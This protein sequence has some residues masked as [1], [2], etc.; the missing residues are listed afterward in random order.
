[1]WL[2]RRSEVRLDV[3][4][5][6][7]GARVLTRYRT[8]TVVGAEEAKTEGALA[9]ALDEFPKHERAVIDVEGLEAL[10]QI[11]WNRGSVFEHGR[12]QA[13]GARGIALGFS[14]NDVGGPTLGFAPRNPAMLWPEHGVTQDRAADRREHRARRE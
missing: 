3:R 14:L 5:I 13:S 7:D 9:L 6:E 2:L 12:T 8:A 1:M 4:S 11:T 10:R